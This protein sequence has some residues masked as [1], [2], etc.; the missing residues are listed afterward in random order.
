MGQVGGFTILPQWGQATSAALAL[1]A[2][3]YWVALRPALLVTVVLVNFAM[4]LPHG[5]GGAAC[6]PWL[7]PIWR[8]RCRNF[9]HGQVR[10]VWFGQ[11]GY[12]APLPIAPPQAVV[13]SKQANAWRAPMVAG[14]QHAPPRLLTT[15][16][17]AGHAQAVQLNLPKLLVATMAAV[18]VFQHVAPIIHRLR[19]AIVFCVF[20]VG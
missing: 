17:P 7:T 11:R 18:K 10:P 3:M 13:L 1:R 14:G 20:Q 9:P 6:P 5:S 2:K 12:K 4:V 8:N 16:Q 15:Q 19:G